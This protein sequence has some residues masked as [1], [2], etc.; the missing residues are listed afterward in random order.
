MKTVLTLVVIFTAFFTTHAD[1]WAFGERENGQYVAMV[2]DGE[3]ENQ[4]IPHSKLKSLAMFNLDKKN[5]LTFLVTLFEY[6]EYPVISNQ[7]TRHTVQVDI[8]G[9]TTL[10]EVQHPVN[11]EDIV[12]G[13]AATHKIAMAL[14]HGQ[15]V[16]LSIQIDS[17]VY[18][19]KLEAEGFN[20]EFNR[21]VAA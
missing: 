15:D 5:N 20:E 18:E 17:N 6:G 11:K 10:Y 4:V 21:W 13:K 7:D 9:K 3:F 16:E 1:N 12:F 14:H 2:A 8:D 19:F